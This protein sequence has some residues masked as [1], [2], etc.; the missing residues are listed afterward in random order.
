MRNLKC[1][2]YW[3]IDLNKVIRLQVIQRLRPRCVFCGKCERLSKGNFVKFTNNFEIATAIR[4]HLITDGKLPAL[5][6]HSKQHFKKLFGR[7]LQLRQI[8]S[9]GCNAC[10]SDLNVLA[11]P[12]FDLARFRI[13]FVT[14]L[15]SSC[16]W[17]SGNRTNIKE[18]ES[19][20]PRY[21]WSST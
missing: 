14:S 21:L 19:S 17:H 11:T 1:L 7:S 2:K 4:E 15:P 10:E 5:E 3:K 12:F 6:E 9:A 20:C 18:Y 13:N 16:G 8:S